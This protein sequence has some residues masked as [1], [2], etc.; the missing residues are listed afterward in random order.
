MN[1]PKVNTTQLLISTLGTMI[2]V[3]AAFFLNSWGENR[4]MQIEM[5]KRLEKIYAELS[6]NQQKVASTYDELSDFFA[7]IS[8]IEDLQ[9]VRITQAQMQEFR[10]QTDWV[11]AI[12]STKIA[13]YE[14]SYT[15]G[16]A[17]DLPA[18]AEISD[19]A[20]TLSESSD[21]FAALSFDCL[22]ALQNIYAI[23]T[24]L[25]VEMDK[26]EEIIVESR[27]VLSIERFIQKRVQLI[28]VY[29]KILLELYE[30]HLGEKCG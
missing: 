15:M 7:V 29:E 24:K 23:Q 26:L 25:K 5:E 21:A 17:L 28:L 14:F 9:D 4:N 6:S 18:S 13:D 19:L 16:I 1:H 22:Y 10:H 8:Q 20:W 11:Y 12:D 3:L 2:G 27:Q 30:I